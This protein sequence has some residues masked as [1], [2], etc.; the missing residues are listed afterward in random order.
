MPKAFN[1]FLPLRESMKLHMGDLVSA[2]KELLDMSLSSGK[3]CDL[4]PYDVSNT[5][6][7]SHCD[8]VKNKFECLKQLPNIWAV[9]VIK[10]S[11]IWEESL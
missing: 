2:C 5:G 1:S 11:I 8:L 3:R 10:Q 4:K 7:Q 6:D 9:E